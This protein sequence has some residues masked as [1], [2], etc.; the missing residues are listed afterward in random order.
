ML[1][2]R[3]A[4]RFRRSCIVI[5]AM[6]NNTYAWT[7]FPS[8]AIVASMPAEEPHALFCSSK[9]V[10][11]DFCSSDS[12]QR[13]IT[14]STWYSASGYRYHTCIN[15][16]DKM[17]IRFVIMS[18]KFAPFQAASQTRLDPQKDIRYKHPIQAPM[19]WLSWQVIFNENWRNI[20]VPIC[21]CLVTNILET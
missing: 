14:K 6:T 16:H 20:C 5:D 12:F 4:S 2:F 13:S 15:L 9:G 18:L 3:T 1:W 19:S 7:I 8:L 17:Y 11:F 21:G 10:W